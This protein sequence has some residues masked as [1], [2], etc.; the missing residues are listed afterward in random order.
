MWT[1]CD[2]QQ[3]GVLTSVDSDE[4]VQPPVKFKNS[5]WCSVSS[6]TVKKICKRLAKALIRLRVYADWSEPL[7][8]AHTTLLEISC[9]G[10]NV[11]CGRHVIPN[12]VAF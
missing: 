7:L 12:N 11:I 5:K 10:S 2:F 8:V 1:T 6:F 3:C 4:P 9:R